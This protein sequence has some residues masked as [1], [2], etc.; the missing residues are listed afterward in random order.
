MHLTMKAEKGNFSQ[1]RTLRSNLHTL[2]SSTLCR[3]HLPHFVEACSILYG[4]AVKGNFA[5]LHT[6]WRPPLH[7]AETSGSKRG[8][9]DINIKCCT[10]SRKT[11]HVYLQYRGR[12]N[13]RSIFCAYHPID[14]PQLCLR[15]HYVQAS[16]VV[17]RQRELACLLPISCHKHYSQSAVIH[18]L[19]YWCKV[20]NPQS[21]SACKLDQATNNHTALCNHIASTGFTSVHCMQA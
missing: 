3:D 13:V 6:L 4:Q 5:Q 10:L 8:V 9:G 14:R 1:F 16:A 18:S 17:Q 20:P 11:A 12:N 15:R 2:W 7:S 19:H 21:C